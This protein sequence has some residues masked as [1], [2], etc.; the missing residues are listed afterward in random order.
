MVTD[1]TGSVDL[2]AC[3]G[4]YCGAC[5]ARVKGRCAGCR[6]STKREWCKVRACCTQRGHATCA[7]CREHPDPRDCRIFNN[8]IARV[9]GF[10]FRSDR[11]ACIAQIRH[12][13]IEKHAAWM[14]E[15]RR[16]SIP[17]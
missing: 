2:V 17:R 12:M 3:C 9:F 1:Y 5:R 14:A 11:A 7:E 16:H 10:V 4:L 8:P 15:C 13:G 6:A